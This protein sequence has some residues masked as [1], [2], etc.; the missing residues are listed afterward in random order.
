MLLPLTPRLTSPS[1]SFC[2]L[3]TPGEGTGQREEIQALFAHL[4]HLT[5]P[6]HQR[7]PWG[8]VGAFNNL[9]VIFYLLTVEAIFFPML[10]EMPVA[11]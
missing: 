11:H 5:A 8:T 9:F 7:H 6:P 4:P 10:Q 2:F 3:A 1:P